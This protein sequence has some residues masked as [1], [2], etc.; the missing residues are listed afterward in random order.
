MADT[1]RTL[2][3]LNTLLADNTSGDITPQDIRDLMV[4]MMVHAEIGA[5]DNS[6]ITLGSGWETVDLDTAGAAKRG[7]DVDLVN[8]RITSIPVACKGQVHWEAEFKGA[9][10]T[11]YEF[12]VYRNGG[13]TQV[14]GLYRRAY[15]PTADH[16]VHVGGTVTAYLSQDETLELAVKASGASFELLSAVL[17]IDRIGVE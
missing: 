1:I 7:A 3:E 6:P 17:R 13:P 5:L 4:S 2:A 12:A 14:I 11:L 10:A 8:H 9:A 15:V 16:I